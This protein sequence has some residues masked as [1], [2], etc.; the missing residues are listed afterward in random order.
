MPTF[1]RYDIKQKVNGAIKNKQDVLVDYDRTVNFAV[2]D[3]LSEID[4]QSPRRRSYLD[5]GLFPEVYAY[6]APD[7]LWGLAR[8]DM[9]RAQGYARKR[10][11][12]MWG[13]TGNPGNHG[14]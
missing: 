14:S 7:E 4:I 10:G 3:V 2:R 13:T 8:R 6:A 9:I 5:P 12:G 11:L 1:T